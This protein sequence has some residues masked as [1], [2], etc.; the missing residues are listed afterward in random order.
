MAT[1]TD[2]RPVTILIA[3]DHQLFRESLRT[4]LEMSGEFRVV[5]QSADG[6]DTIR[7]T[8]ELRPDVLLL[9]LMM[10]VTSGLTALRELSTLNLPVRTLVLT[11]E[12]GDPDIVEALQLGARGVVLKQ[13]AT[14]TL[15]KAIR[16]VLAGEHWV[17]HE[18]V[19]DLVERV[20]RRAAPASPPPVSFTPRQLDIVSA[21]VAGGT[22][23][24][25]AKQFS[26][27]PTTV[28]YHL[29][30]MFEKVGV[31]NRVELA[32]FAVQHRIEASH[33]RH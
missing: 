11:A 9:D 31:S 4:L 13:V 25:I 14:E 3:D 23:R 10:P 1:Q 21:I 15:F 26:I 24:D 33:P 2:Q 8:R 16:A 6:R 12:A 27:T 30:H 28:K 17:C 20:R 22:N 29:T 32:R 5:G 19:G 7:L 18:C